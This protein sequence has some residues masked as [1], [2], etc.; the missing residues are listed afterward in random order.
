MDFTAR[1]KR[2]FPP[3]R[4]VFGSLW[5]WLAF[6]LGT[7]LLRPGPGT[8]GTVLAWGMWLL[9]LQNLS[10]SALAILLIVSFV[11]GCWLCDRVGREIGIEDHSGINWD[12]WVA[13]LLVLACIPAAFAWQVV[14]FVLFRFF[15]I[16][17]PVPI[18]Q[19]DRQLKGG[20]G[21]MVDDILAALY[22]LLGVWVIYY[23]VTA[24]GIQ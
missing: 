19:V 16:A 2:D 4:W 6:G 17:K 22:A 8:W 15:D 21:V 7:G 3:V 18:R 13:F 10:G 23:L 12:E 1:S 14:A 20:V 5:R 9:G 11:F 24:F